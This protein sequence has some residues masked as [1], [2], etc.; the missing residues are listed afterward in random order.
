MK[1]LLSA[2]S[3]IVYNQSCSVQQTMI[4]VV[5]LILKLFYVSACAVLVVVKLFHFC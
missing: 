1:T 3:N 4:F 5:K 2:A